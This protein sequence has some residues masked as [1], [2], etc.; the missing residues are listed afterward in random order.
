VCFA[1]HNHAQGC[2][3]E[4]QKHVPLGIPDIP[5]GSQELIGRFPQ[6]ESAPPFKQFIEG[7]ERQGNTN[8]QERQPLTVPEGRAAYQN[9][10]GQK[11]GDEPLSE[12]T[13]AVV[14][15]A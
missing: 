11:G 2:P 5:L 12:M 10:P 15:V 8:N 3:G 14:V 13:Q 4:R 1:E 9:F 7:A 6:N